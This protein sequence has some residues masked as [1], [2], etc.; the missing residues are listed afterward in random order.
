M[1]NVQDILT[2]EECTSILQNY[3][4][5]TDCQLISYKIEPLSTR[6]GFLGEYFTIILQYRLH[7]QES[8][9]YFFLKTINNSSKIM[10]ELCSDLHAYEKER[11]FYTVLIP[12]YKKYNIETN[13]APKY[14]ACRPDY[15]VL[16]DLSKQGF[17]GRPKTQFLDIEHCREALK[18]LAVFHAS[19]IAYEELKSLEEEG[20]FRLIDQ[21]FH[22]QHLQDS[23]MSGKENSAT[24][25][26]NGA[27]EGMFQLIA[28]LPEEEC[29]K[30]NFAEKLKNTLTNIFE[31]ERFKECRGAV[32][33]ADVWCNNFLY[34]CKESSPIA[35]KLVDYQT[36]KYGPPALDIA[37]F[38]FSNTRKALRDQHKHELLEFYYTYLN[39]NLNKLG[40]DCNSILPKDE[41]TKIYA[42]AEITAKLQA[43]G[44]R[45][46][47][48]AS[49]KDFAEALKSEETLCAFILED[50]SKNM[51]KSFKTNELFKELM[52]EDMMELKSMICNT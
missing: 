25:W 13:F 9:C 19:S 29:A 31:E 41:F 44:D 7:K 16:D 50:V 5:S 47:T 39:Q 28:Y 6:G 22:S 3:L 48:F 8:S 4:D 27:I 18:T 34:L 20:K 36:I 52:L 49:D 32:L 12:E 30:E 23:M 1:K 46:I 42:E 24:K 10:T 11:H 45:A 43:L 2:K 38:I 26:L 17:K 37:H 40:L 51:I 15:V 21:D 14:Y 33:H 35:C